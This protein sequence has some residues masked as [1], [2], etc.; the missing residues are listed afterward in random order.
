MTIRCPAVVMLFVF[1]AIPAQAQDAASEDPQERARA[2]RGLGEQG[3]T[4]IAALTI[5]LKDPVLNVRREAVKSIV[6]IGTQ[7]S[8]DALVEATKD[9]DAEIQIR[10]ADGLV[11]FYY[12]GYASTGLTASLKGVGTSIKGKFTD[13]NDQVIPPYMEVRPG[14]I[15]ALGKL[16]RAGSGRMARA[17][18]SR[19]VGVLRGKAAI[20]DLLEAVRSKD[21]QILYESLNAIQKIRDPSAGPGIA[22]LLRDLDDRVQVAAIETTGLLQNRDA[23]PQLYDVLDSAR[24]NKIRRA[25]LTAIGMLPDEKSRPLYNRYI[26]HKHSP[27]R[28]AAAEGFARL[29]NP[30]DVPT[31]ETRFEE[32]KKMKPRLSLAF[33]LVMLGSTELREFSPLQYLVN[34]LNSSSFRGFAQPFLEELARDLA[35]RQSLYGALPAGTKHEKIRLARVLGR[36]GDEQTIPH[37]ERL[38]KDP[39][40]QVATEGAAAL[41][42]LRARL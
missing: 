11:N 6:K 40:T 36:S 28:A 22:F 27:T 19:A 42:T 26:R 7:H 20:P 14:V 1:L 10:A 39:D 24:N 18:A 29:K 37:L 33:A 2:A 13:V 5:L 38:T 15:E 41:R 32:E 16:V 8:L 31:L 3:S 21:S 30:A 35:V 9:T 17:N 4:G 23:L 34:T 12:P 25:A